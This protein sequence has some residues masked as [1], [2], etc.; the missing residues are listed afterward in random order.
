MIF[1]RLVFAGLVYLTC[2]MLGVTD[3]RIHNVENVRKIAGKFS[4]ES[5]Y[6]RHEKEHENYPGKVNVQKDPIPIGP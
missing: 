1:W 6:S 2:L 5:S 3:Q 4:K